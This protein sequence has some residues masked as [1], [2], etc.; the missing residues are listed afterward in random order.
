MHSKRPGH[1]P[2]GRHSERFLFD[3][4]SAELVK[5]RQRTGLMREWLAKAI[6]AWNGKEFSDQGAAVKGVQGELVRIGRDRS[7]YIDMAARNSSAKQSSSRS[8][9]S[10]TMRAASCVSDSPSFRVPTQQRLIGE[11]NG[12][13]NFRKPLRKVGYGYKYRKA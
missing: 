1:S 4:V 13:S 9:K 10:A 7:G 11:P 12:L 8:A 6:A 2:E 3:A 5:F